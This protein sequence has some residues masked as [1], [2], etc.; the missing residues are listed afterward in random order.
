[1]A[2]DLQKATC[3]LRLSKTRCVKRM[4]RRYRTEFGVGPPSKPSIYA[5]YKQFCEADCLSRIPFAEAVRM[6]LEYQLVLY[7]VTTSRARI[8][9]L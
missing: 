4:Q 8:E 7:K 3:F 2:T 1:M 6:K 9:Y 5:F